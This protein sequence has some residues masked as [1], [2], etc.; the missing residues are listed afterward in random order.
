M[1]LKCTLVA[2]LWVSAS[3]AAI[4]KLQVTNSSHPCCRWHWFPPRR[5]RQ[6]SAVWFYCMEQHWCGLWAWVWWK[7]PSLRVPP[8]HPIAGN[9]LSQYPPS[10]SWQSYLWALCEIRP[11]GEKKG[12]QVA[13]RA[14]QCFVTTERCGYSPEWH[15]QRA[16]HSTKL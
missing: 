3:S 10:Q 4:W 15:P 12:G 11:S 9:Q 13:N 8:L 2:T 7:S 14:Q 1:S 6:T 5:D 16:G